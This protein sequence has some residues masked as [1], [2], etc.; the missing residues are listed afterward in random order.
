M[1]MVAR[2]ARRGLAC[3]AAALVAGALAPGAARATDRLERVQ[4]LAVRP[5]GG[6]VHRIQVPASAVKYDADTGVFHI[7]LAT[8]DGRILAATEV[9]K[10]GGYLARTRQ[11]YPFHVRREEV[12]LHELEV[13]EG[14]ELV[15]DLRIRAPRA[16]AG[17]LM[18]DLVAICDLRV[19]PAAD[20]SAVRETV[21]RHR[22]SAEAP[23]AGPVRTRVLRVALLSVTLQGARSGE[24]HARVA[25]GPVVAQGPVPDAAR[26]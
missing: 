26:R 14:G 19:L 15:R 24:V 21:E 6:A 4:E 1:T 7:R 11:G 3:A 12:S 17:E 16:R 8:G 18:H 22:T 10:R 25:A 9:V 2:A 20:G 13:V 5:V 23:L